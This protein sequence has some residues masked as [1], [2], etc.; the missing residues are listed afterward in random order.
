MFDS[1]LGTRMGSMATLLRRQHARLDDLDAEEFSRP[2]GH[3]TD[4]QR[5]A[6]VDDIHGPIIRSELV[7]KVGVEPTR[8]LP[9]NGF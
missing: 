2:L 4:L 9:P 5:P 3:A 7:P 1:T 8:A 6:T